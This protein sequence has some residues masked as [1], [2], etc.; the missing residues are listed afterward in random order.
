[1]YKHLSLIALLSV[2]VLVPGCWCCKKDDTCRT[3]TPRKEKKVEQNMDME[4]ASL[5]DLYDEITEEELRLAEAELDNEL[6]ELTSET[7]APRK[8]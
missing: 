3:C 5:A 6:L 8:M 2:L 7:E 1:M 4:M